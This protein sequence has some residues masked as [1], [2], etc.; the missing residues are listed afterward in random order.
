MNILRREVPVTKAAGKEVSPEPAVS[1]RIEVTVER[2]TVTI[3][4]RGQLKE[5][6]EERANG[7]SDPESERPRMPSS[8]PVL[9]NPFQVCPT[10]GSSSVVLLAEALPGLDLTLLKAETAD[11]RVHLHR[12]PSGEWWICKQ[13]LHLS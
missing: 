2:E 9:K 1:R 6:T 11:G 5:G 10:C 4:V 7:D 13:S 12:S 8:L 3:L